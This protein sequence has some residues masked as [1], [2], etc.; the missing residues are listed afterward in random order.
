MPNLRRD[1]LPRDWQHSASDLIFS[2]AQRSIPPH[3]QGRARTSA[4]TRR[5]NQL[6]KLIQ[7][8]FYGNAQITSAV[9]TDIWIQACRLADAH[10][11]EDADY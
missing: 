11:P 7:S 6:A 8:E 5:N 2:I 4:A 10:H 3:I 9:S 1:L